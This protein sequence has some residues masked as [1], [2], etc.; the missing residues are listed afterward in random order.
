VSLSSSP[1]HF[2]FSPPPSTP[3]LSYP[4][5]LLFS[6]PFYLSVFN[7]VFWEIKAP[8]R[9]FPLQFLGSY[10]KTSK[11]FNPSPYRG[12]FFPF[13]TPSPGAPFSC[14]YSCVLSAFYA[15]Q[16]SM[17]AAV[18]FFEHLERYRSDQVRLFFFFSFLVRVT[19]SSCP[20]SLFVFRHPSTDGLVGRGILHGQIK[21]KLFF[22]SHP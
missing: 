20:P 15:Q 4:L 14:T 6:P 16:R 3:L 9:A 5:P 12:L 22:S 11:S 18:H 7:P 19:L 21:N 2:S 8:Y 13:Q 17:A 10:E 1:F